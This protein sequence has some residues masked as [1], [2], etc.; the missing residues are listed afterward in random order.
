[1]GA[2]L[3]IIRFDDE[4]DCAMDVWAGV[5]PLNLAAGK[6]IADER[7]KSGIE[8]PDYAENYLRLAK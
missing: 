1:M 3:L 6:P 4:E 2:R 7:L 8:I 5:I